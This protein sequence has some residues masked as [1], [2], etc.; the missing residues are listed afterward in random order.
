M[1]NDLGVLDRMPARD[2]LLPDTPDRCKPP[3]GRSG[4]P[5]TR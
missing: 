4:P 5:I 2:E 3:E 1:E